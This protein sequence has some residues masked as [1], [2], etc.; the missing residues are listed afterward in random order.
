MPRRTGS[1]VA[2][3]DQRDE[4]GRP[5][6]ELGSDPLLRTAGVGESISANHSAGRLRT[7]YV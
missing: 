3:G 2:I 1:G 5:T 6:V 4:F 7:A